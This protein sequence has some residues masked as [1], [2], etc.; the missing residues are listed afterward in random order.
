ML[1]IF[2]I[3]I[4]KKFLSFVLLIHKENLY[5]RLN[6]IHKSFR[7]FL[8][9]YLLASS[10]VGRQFFFTGMFE[11]TGLDYLFPKGDW[12]VV[13]HYIITPNKGTPFC[14]HF[15]RLIFLG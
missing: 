5:S 2:R 6:V 12:Q 15:S 14:F 7:F 4:V 9:S 3:C 10:F 8:F 11:L 1:I 13:N